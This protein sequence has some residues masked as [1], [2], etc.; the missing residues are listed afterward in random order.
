MHIRVDRPSLTPQSRI[1][2][3][4]SPSPFCTPLR[5]D[6]N[7][8]Y[9][10]SRSLTVNEGGV[11]VFISSPLSSLLLLASDSLWLWMVLFA[12]TT[13]CRRAA[14]PATVEDWGAARE[15]AMVEGRRQGGK[16]MGWKS[17][18]VGVNVYT[19]YLLLLLLDMRER[20]GWGERDETT[21]QFSFYTSC[22]SV[23]KVRDS[24]SRSLKRPACLAGAKRYNST[25]REVRSDRLRSYWIA[26]DSGVI[27]GISSM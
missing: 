3:E 12:V 5:L 13:R 9:S 21:L 8:V 16:G 25:E 23:Q 26:R 17:N 15:V 14:A 7:T 10:P 6:G 2:Y 27:H 18:E 24:P 1:I 20:D 22:P 4:N 11:K 19:L